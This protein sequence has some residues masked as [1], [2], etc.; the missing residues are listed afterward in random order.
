MAAWISSLRQYSFKRYL[1]R[2]FIWLPEYL[3]WDNILS[4]NICLEYSYGCLNIFL[5]NKIFVHNIRLECSYGCLN[6]FFNKIFVH[7][8]R[9]KCSYCCLNIFFFNKI[10]FQTKYLFIQIFIL[11]PAVWIFRIFWISWIFWK[12]SRNESLPASWIQNILSYDICLEYSYCSTLFEYLWQNICTECLCYYQLCEYSRLNLPFWTFLGWDWPFGL[13]WGLRH[14]SEP[15]PQWE[16]INIVWKEL[17]GGIL[18]P[19]NYL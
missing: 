8:I 6:I 9:L 15:F 14:P 3:L 12:S 17:F 4:N 18:Y 16:F 13:F 10:F 5:F 11:L 7:N 19:Q 2:I 1:F